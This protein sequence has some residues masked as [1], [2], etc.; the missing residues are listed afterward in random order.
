M[1]V[2]IPLMIQEPATSLS[3]IAGR[4]AKLYDTRV[5]T[6]GLGRYVDIEFKG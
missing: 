2:N 4:C 1:K 3:L 5:D 6:A